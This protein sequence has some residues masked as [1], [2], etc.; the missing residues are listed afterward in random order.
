MKWS[1]KLQ[2]TVALSTAESEVYAAVSA[3][4]EIEFM[5]AFLSDLGYPTA[6]HPS[7]LYE[8]NKACIAL[9]SNLRNRSKAK[10]Y[11]R[12]LHYLQ[13]VVARGVAKFTHCPTD[14]MY[15]DILTKHLARVKFQYFKSRILGNHTNTQQATTT[16]PNLS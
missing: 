5:R 6:A 13:D 15:A 14:E 16:I 8:D 12:T 3:A 1:S 4:N 9:G 7:R 2:S 10:K 11:V